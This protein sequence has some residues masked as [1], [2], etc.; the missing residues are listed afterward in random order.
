[1]EAKSLRIL[2]IAWA[3]ATVSAPAKELITVPVGLTEPLSATDSTSS[4]RYRERFEAAVNFALGENEKALNRCGYRYLLQPRYFDSSNKEAGA[5]AG[6]ELTQSQVWAVF[7]PRRSEDFI[8]VGSRLKNAVFVTPMA[9]SNDVNQLGFPHFTMYP[10]TQDFSRLLV[11]ALKRERYGKRYAAVVDVT[12]PACKDLDKEFGRVPGYQRAFTYDIAADEPALTGLADQIRAAEANGK[13]DF[14]LLP[15]NS[16]ASGFV[17]S[18]L[19]KDFPH[20]KYVGAHGWGDAHY[21]FLFAYGIDKTV[22]GFCLR[23]GREFGEMAKAHGVQSIDYLWKGARVAP[24]YTAFSA[25][26]FFRV[27]TQSLCHVKP[28]DQADF[29]KKMQKVSR[30]HFRFREPISVY[31]LSEGKLGF[32]YSIGN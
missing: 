2:F 3:L 21:G 24:N 29:L 13:L 31:Q 23:A 12:C 20:L 26:H 6:D 10:T 19:Q 25:I 9:N 11:E 18:H 15:N 28:T 8:T 16:R 32:G 22:K 14:I 7:G 17:I 4:Q 30:T 1:M 27:L 5:Q